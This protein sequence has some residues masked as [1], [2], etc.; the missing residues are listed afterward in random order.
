MTNRDSHI[1]TLITNPFSRNEDE[2]EFTV[3]IPL[4]NPK[5]EAHLISLGA[6]IAN[7]QNGQVIAVTII[8][9]PDQTS[10]RAARDQLEYQESTD[11]LQGAERDAAEFGAPI[12]TRTIFSHQL[13]KTIF[14]A[15]RNVDADVCLMGWGP[16]SP[17]FAGRAE[18]VVDELARSLSCDFLV[19]KDR[20]FD[21]SRVLLPTTGGPHTD[22]AAAV[23]RIL[24][25]EFGSDVTLLHV[26]DDP[27]EGDAFLR[28]WAAD[29]D[30]RETT[31]QIETGDV[32]E[33]IENAAREH[34][35]ILIG[36]TQAGVLSRLVRGSLVL[37]VL[38]D[39]DCSVLITERETKR[40]L[41]SRF[42]GQR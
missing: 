3:L 39:V 38:N 28:S 20:G 24:Q 19:F 26:A 5:T 31:L 40:G 12:E 33:A 27:E 30:L 22:M 36:A 11:M 4:A 10:L 6:A 9:V 42:V 25:E 32:E 2:G 29:H 34:T 1:P 14:N 13:F 16:D 41:L 17:G 18:S 21:P 7:Q 15:A 37:D 23:A 35:L 8:K